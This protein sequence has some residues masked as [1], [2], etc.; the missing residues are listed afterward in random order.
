MFFIHRPTDT[1]AQQ[2]VDRGEAHY[3]KLQHQLLGDDLPTTRYQ[4]GQLEVRV[5]LGDGMDE[6]VFV[7]NDIADLLILGRPSTLAS[8]GQSVS[9]AA[10]A[11]LTQPNPAE[12]IVKRIQG[13]FVLA[14]A[15]RKSGEWE[16]R[17]D[18]MGMARLFSYNIG[19]EFIL[20][21]SVFAIASCVR[22]ELDKAYACMLDISDLIW[23]YK[24]LYEG[25]RAVEVGE[26]VVGDS[27]A[28][29]ISLEWHFADAS[30]PE[31]TV[32][33]VVSAYGDAM[34][35][36][37]KNL[38]R[39][40]HCMTGGVD[41]RTLLGLTMHH[42]IK[43]S[44]FFTR[45]IK[46]DCEIAYKAAHELALDCHTTV[47]PRFL[48]PDQ[49]FAGSHLAELFLTEG[50]T[51]GVFGVRD[52]RWTVGPNDAISLGSYSEGL[53]RSIWG[54]AYY[55]MRKTSLPKIADR[56]LGLN[57]I[58]FARLRD[59][60][61]N[62]LQDDAT[63]YIRSTLES[64]A[65]VYSSSDPCKQTHYYFLRNRCGRFH[66]QIAYAFN[67]VSRSEIPASFLAGACEAWK[68]PSSVYKELSLCRQI[69][70]QCEPRLSTFPFCCGSSAKEQLNLWDRGK[71][72]YNRVAGKAIKV[73]KSKLKR[74]ALG[75][76]PGKGWGSDPIGGKQYW[77]LA[78]EWLLENSQRR[79]LGLLRPTP[80]SD[81]IKAV[82]MK[83][84][85]LKTIATLEFASRVY[86][87]DF[88][89]V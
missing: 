79:T 65:N 89:Q 41:S 26:A 67:R 74:R 4:V 68:V 1:H 47:A 73:L 63:A 70:A 31:P 22:L 66:G 23:G 57:A 37:M 62:D 12:Y 7:E 56:L 52:Y 35:P 49:T 50:H 44:I 27:T 29:R 77:D 33:D 71:M 25:V 21:N 28:S 60:F 85:H 86:D 34:I 39:V 14:Y 32:S 19:D 6:P 3:L 69:L 83:S 2:H 76:K 45:T 8:A 55:G 64:Q 82:W 11:A 58:R 40:H 9:Q 16:V 15:N 81:E 88:P 10:L 36:R 61:S 72:F 75:A 18:G 54:V 17:G 38:N 42:G 80:D 78:P 48:G 51:R 59:A 43:P 53:L 87:G 5:G 84:G 20:S 46:E 30:G 24:T 13:D